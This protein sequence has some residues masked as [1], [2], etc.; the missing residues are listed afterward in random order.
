M[1]EKNDNKQAVTGDRP[2]RTRPA[3]PMYPGGMM[4]GEEEKQ[5]VLEVLKNKHLFRYYS[6]FDTDSKVAQLEKDFAEKNGVRHVLALSSGTAALVTGMV[7]MGIGPGDEVVVPAYTFVA[8]PMAVLEAKAI[9]ILAEIDKSMG[10]DPRSVEAAI[11][12]HTKAIMPVHMR[13]CSCD[14]DIIMD[15]AEKYN[16]Q[17]IEDCAQA[18]GGSYKGKKLGSFGNV[19]CF[20]LQF[21]KN[22]TSGEGGILVTGDENIYNRSLMYHDCTGGWR[23]GRD[24]AFAIPGTNYRMNELCGAVACVQLQKLDAIVSSMHHH[25]YRVLEYLRGIGR[26]E[27]QRIP[28]EKGD[29]GF[30]LNFFVSSSQKALQIEQALTAE[31][32][33]VAVI[34]KGK[35]NSHV[36]SGWP[37]LLNKTSA[38]PT[39][40]PFTCPFYKGRAEYSEK[41]FPKTLDLLSRT[42]SLK[43]SPLLT[44]TDVDEIIDALDKVLEALL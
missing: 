24:V 22:I 36:Y 37:H 1:S 28:D 41:M 12:E 23:T 14:M 43:F 16:L 40:C 18:I 32:I 6:P 33:D 34:Y 10:L 25:K 8:S 13:G 21:N 5:A 35:P 19:G 9:P 4:I 7:A 31:G 26:V 44:D 3:P 29:T 27:L 39:G 17:V 20:S 38:H 15:I 11:T 30:S 42:V 2:T